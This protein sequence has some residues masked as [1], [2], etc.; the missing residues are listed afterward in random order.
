MINWNCILY[1]HYTAYGSV[2]HNLSFS[3]PHWGFLCPHYYKCPFRWEHLLAIL[4]LKYIIF[5]TSVSGTFSCVIFMQGGFHYHNSSSRL[6]ERTCPA[7]GWCTNLWITKPVMGH[8]M[9]FFQMV[10]YWRILLFSNICLSL[11]HPSLTLFCIW[12]LQAH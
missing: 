3:K 5:L 4:C 12:P 1:W 11:L 7:L 10:K 8:H 9:T 6:T 2:K